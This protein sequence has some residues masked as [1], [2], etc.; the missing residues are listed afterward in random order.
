MAEDAAAPRRLATG[1]ARSLAR[2]RPPEPPEGMVSRVRLR[3]LLSSIAATERVIVLS[4]PSGYGKTLAV[5]DWLSGRDDAVAWLSLGLLDSGEE[6]VASGIV[7]ALQSATKSMDPGPTAPIETSSVGSRATFGMLLDELDEPVTLVIDDAQRAGAALRTGLLGSLIEHGPELLRIVLIGT[8]LLELEMSRHVLTR[9]NSV[10]R[11]PQLA[12]D[13]PEVAA[14]VHPDRTLSPAL[15]MQQTDGWPIAVRLFTLAAR[16]EFNHFEEG[17][18]LLRDYLR[19]HVLAGLPKPL[20]DFALDTTLGI[21]LTPELAAAISERD[22]AKALLE[23]C[24]RRG[25][26]L[27]RVNTPGGSV[28]RWHGMFAQQCRTIVGAA[29]PDH[30]RAAHARAA[31]ALEAD[32]P[33]SAIDQWLE[34]GRPEEAMRVI[35]LSWMWLLVGSDLRGF[36]LLC[37]TLPAPFADDP[38]VLLIRACAQQI[39]GTSE[40]ARQLEARALHRAGGGRTP[41]GYDE[42]LRLSQLILTTDA[43]ALERHIAEAYEALSSLERLLPRQ[44]VAVLYVMGWAGLR[45]GGDATRAERVLLAAA[46]ESEALGELELTRGA[47]GRLA[48]LLSWSGELSRA[49][50]ML[51][52]L[53]GLGGGDD[54]GHWQAFAGG[55]ASLAEGICAFWANDL[56]S[57]ETALTRVVRSNGVSPTTAGLARVLL[58]FTANAMRDLDVV[59]R[60]TREAQA[61]PN[62][63]DRGIPWGAYRAAAL[64]ALHEAS[65]QR[66]QREIGLGLAVSFPGDPLASPLMITLLAIMLCRAGHSQQALRLMLPLQPIDRV[67]YVRVM[68]LLMAALSCRRDGERNETHRLCELALAAA[69]AEEMRRPFADASLEVRQLLTEHLAWGTAHE[70]FAVSCLTPGEADGPLEQLSERERE[71]F[72]QLRTTRTIQEIADALGVSVNTVKSHQRAIY[73]KLSVASRREAVRRFG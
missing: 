3:L 29:D 49:R 47:L 4:A 42:I 8:T 23:E 19:D 14:L 1:G 66:E 63:D 68:M 12:F 11:A 58:A 38:R 36:D 28:Y 17:S 61:I 16:S 30:L 18:A 21:D 26:F 25:L 5:S 51:D 33:L 32:D 10:L 7:R 45:L 37:S 34:A 54:T 52:R 46:D 50:Q 15:I 20:R 67:P 71:V 53:A 55:S 35:L 60:A 39:L 6:A 56:K 70:E 73:R 2:Y 72:S 43:D 65:E 13:L 31:A 40:L 41:A 48:A 9:P 57:A 44:R 59:R 22:D 64:A 69:S 24:A 62:D 27:S